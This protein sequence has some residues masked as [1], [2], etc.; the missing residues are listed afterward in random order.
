MDTLITPVPCPGWMRAVTD[1]GLKRP[2]SPARDAPGPDESVA[3]EPRRV[4]RARA[5]LRK[6]DPAIS[7][8]G[9]HRQAFKI[10]CKIVHGYELP[11][12][13]A[14]SLLLEEWNPRC[15][16]PWSE[17]ELRH[18]VESALKDGECPVFPDRNGHGNGAPST[19]R[20]PTEDKDTPE[21]DES[22]PALPAAAEVQ[23]REWEWLWYGW[24]AR[25]TLACLDGMPGVG[26][27]TLMCAFAAHVTGGPP[28]PGAG[29][30]RDAPG[31]VLFFPGE[32][33]PAR[34][35]KP[36][37]KAA[38]ADLSR[39]FIPTAEEGGGPP[40]WPQLPADAGK[41]ESYIRQYRVLLVILDPLNSFVGS[42]YNLNLDECVRDLL[43]PLIR[44]A[45]DT[46]CTILFTR[47]TGKA[48]G[49]P[50]VHQGIGGVGIT[51]C[52]RTVLLAGPPPAPQ[53]G[54]VLAVS[55]GNLA[56]KGQGLAY[57]I[58][59]PQGAPSIDW[60]GQ[61]AVDADQMSEGIL[62]AGDADELGDAE[63]F[64]RSYLASRWAKAKEVIEEARKSAGVGERRL[65]DAKAKL[66]VQ[67]RHHKTK[68]EDWWEWGPPKDG[69]PPDRK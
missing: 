55:K 45:R 30:R 33:D 11:V 32:D 31:G 36:R 38:G 10:A 25:G 22:L 39:V 35:L 23:S 20:P 49:R 14:L 51:G 34:Y 17:E 4:R 68:D 8:Q 21:S 28:L 42:A 46:G 57:A 52:C 64:L 60:K 15:L 1:P 66:K 16:P 67:S 12:D 44:V 13:K 56:E 27:S 26:K 47:H 50:A 19:R 43:Q 61:T 7:G 58:A 2:R 59:G 54:L 63:R 65:R 40:W 48:K 3:G 69:W 53:S 62:S 29:G 6:C 9:G 5:Y 37:L 18:K 24:V 41:L